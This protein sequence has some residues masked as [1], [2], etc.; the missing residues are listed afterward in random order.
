MAPEINQRIEM[1]AS[2]GDKMN[3]TQLP[4]KWER[5]FWHFLIED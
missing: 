3:E 2:S 1:D 5:R 4:E